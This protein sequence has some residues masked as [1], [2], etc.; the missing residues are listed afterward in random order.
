MSSVSRELRTLTKA[1]MYINEN[2]C[3]VWYL[4]ILHP[5]E[6]THE[7]APWRRLRRDSCTWDTALEVFVGNWKK[8]LKAGAHMLIQ[9]HLLRVPAGPLQSNWAT[10]ATNP[11]EMDLSAKRIYHSFADDGQVYST[12]FVLFLM[13]IN[14]F[15]LSSVF[16][17]PKYLNS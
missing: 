10:S 2:Q 3:Q 7:S 12:P 1:G 4:Y 14:S 11:Q 13:L 16:L 9:W 6:W 5:K 17:M 8:R 15:H